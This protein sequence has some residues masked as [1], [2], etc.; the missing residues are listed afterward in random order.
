MLL[1]SIWHLNSLL[2]KAVKNICETSQKASDRLILEHNGQE[3]FTNEI[4]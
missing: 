4:A 1:Y 2:F 3:L